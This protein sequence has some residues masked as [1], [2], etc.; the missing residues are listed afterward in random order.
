[1]RSAFLV[2]ILLALGTAAAW[3]LRRGPTWELTET[4]RAPAARYEAAAAS[5]GESLYI[6]GGFDTALVA[7]RDSYRFD[8]ADG[9]WHR[10]SDLP[11]GFNH[12][13]AVFDGRY[14]WLAGGFEGRNPG[15]PIRAVWKYDVQADDWSAG[16]P[17]PEKRAS[18]GLALVG[19]Y[20][21]YFGGFDRNLFPSPGL[22]DHWALPLDESG[23]WTPRAPMPHPRGQFGVV[24]LDGYIYVIGGTTPHLPDPRDFDW[25]HRYDPERDVWEQRR[26]LPKARSHTESTTFVLDGMIV[27]VG[28]YSR[29]GHRLPYQT[30]VTAE[31]TAYDPRSDT[32]I[33]LPE[34]PLPLMAPV[35]LPVGDSIVVTG[36]SAPPNGWDNLQNRTYKGALELPARRT[37]RRR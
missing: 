6:F 29:T 10:L 27:A 20:L 35:A 28:G 19:G 26:S 2:V 9:S 33:Q 13:N 36:G 21:H 25:V 18:G 14:V 5:I 12:A 34:L 15:H 24:V 1:M 4:T 8:P 22:P 16:P 31:V 37:D 23:G 17:L 3:L 7:T 11:M 32:W 30:E